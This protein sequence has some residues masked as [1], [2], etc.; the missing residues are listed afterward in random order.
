LGTN[1]GLLNHLIRP[2]N[3]QSLSDRRGFRG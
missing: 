2:L 1:A 3:E